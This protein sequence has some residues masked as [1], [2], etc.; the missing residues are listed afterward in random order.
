MKVFC[1]RICD[2]VRLEAFVPVCLTGV[3]K[4]VESLLYLCLC[5]GVIKYVESFVPVSVYRCD[6]V[7]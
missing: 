4:Y 5:A 6:Q 7:W 1:T 2:Q 3:I